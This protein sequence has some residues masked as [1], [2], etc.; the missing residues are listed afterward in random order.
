MENLKKLMESKELWV[1]LKPDEPSYMVLKGTYGEK[2]WKELTIPIKETS[3]LKELFFLHD[4]APNIHE[5]ISLDWIYFHQ[6]Q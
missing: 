3:G 6:K 1:D 4:R 2:D 5:E